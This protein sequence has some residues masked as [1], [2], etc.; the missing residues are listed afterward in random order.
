MFA[1]FCTYFTASTNLDGRHSTL[2]QSIVIQNILRSKNLPGPCSGAPEGFAEAR[3][4]DLRHDSLGEA[5]VRREIER[6]ERILS[7]VHSQE[8]HWN[9]RARFSGNPG[10]QHERASI[11]SS[12]EYLAE[13]FLQSCWRVVG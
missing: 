2:N 3:L 7:D 10:S 8:I 5:R 13:F 4:K 1:L 9:R 11:C 12:V 6:I